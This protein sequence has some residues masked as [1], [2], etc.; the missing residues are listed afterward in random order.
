MERG[1]L[2]GNSEP[3]K[4]KIV[5]GRTALRNPGNLAVV[6]VYQ[7]E[8]QQNPNLWLCLYFCGKSGTS[9]VQGS[10]RVVTTLPCRY[11]IL[12]KNSQRQNASAVPI[13]NLFRGTR[14]IIHAIVLRPYL[15]VWKDHMKAFAAKRSKSSTVFCSTSHFFCLRAKSSDQVDLAARGLLKAIKCHF[16]SCLTVRGTKNVEL[17]RRRCQKGLKIRTSEARCRTSGGGG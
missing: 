13:R 5:G 8:M 3:L 17:E 2:L 15:C 11:S 9:A 14:P 16:S 4:L 7:F 12:S 1:A 6:C 10:C